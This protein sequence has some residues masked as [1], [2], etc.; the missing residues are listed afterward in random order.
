MK[1]ARVG[2]KSS[3]GRACYADG[4]RV[5]EDISDS[6]SL[7]IMSKGGQS[8]GIGGLEG[9]KAKRRLD[10]GGSKPV[11]VNVVVASKPDQPAA[12]P[13]P[14]PAPPMAG[15][16]PGLPMRASGGRVNKT[17]AKGVRGSTG[18]QSGKTDAAS[19]R[20]L[21]RRLGTAAKYAGAGAGTIATGNPL[22]G[23]AAGLPG[24]AAEVNSETPNADDL[25]INKI[26]RKNGGVV[27]AAGQSDK[28]EKESQRAA[29]A[30]GGRVNMDAGAGGGLG[31]L[32]KAKAY[33]GK[34]AKGK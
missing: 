22:G 33:G 19:D 15:P 18:T 24:L 3:H 31:R 30:T 8:N 10:R 13:M 32:E 2:N 7:P 29:R 14:P 28:T 27:K 34:P 12:P 16:P 26:G 4:G 20:R 6:G 11:T 23:V 25:Y 1:L 5:E 17:D 21:Q 9:G